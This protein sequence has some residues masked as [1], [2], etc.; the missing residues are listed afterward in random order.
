MLDLNDWRPDAIFVV[1]SDDIDLI[2]SCLADI[3]SS[4][5]ISAAEA[6][7]ALARGAALASAMAVNTLDAQAASVRPHRMSRIGA[8]TSVLAAAVV[9]FVVSLSVALGLLFTPDSGSEHNR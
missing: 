4:P 8:L 9:T 1:G 3:A 2:V 6:D 5:V 7:M